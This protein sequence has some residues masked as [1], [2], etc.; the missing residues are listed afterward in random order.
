MFLATIYMQPTLYR[1]ENTGK[2]LS[3]VVAVGVVKYACFEIGDTVFTFGI[4]NLLYETKQCS[5]TIMR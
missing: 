3:F 5:S 2:Q 4:W 1:K